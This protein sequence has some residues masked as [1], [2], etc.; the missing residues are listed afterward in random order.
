MIKNLIPLTL[1]SLFIGCG[2]GGSSSSKSIDLAEYFPQKSMIKS[3]TE[4]IKQDGDF[5][6]EESRTNI[7]VEPNIITVK[8]DTAVTSIITVLEDKI[9]IEDRENNHTKVFER[10]VNKNDTLFTDS[11]S[12]NI[13]PLKLGT[14]TYGTE[15]TQREENCKLI[16]IVDDFS[17]PPFYEYNNY[18]K[19]HDILKI[20]CTAKTVV[21]TTIKPEYIGQVTR[22]NGTITSANNIYYLYFQ[23]ELG[24]I[25]QIDDDCVIK[26]TPQIEID[27]EADKKQCIGEKYHYIMYHREY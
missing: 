14:E 16:D 18:D 4:T 22:E 6:T 2:G 5:T 8:N 15:T 10:K 11:Y 3:Y 7:I 13:T 23:K 20:K 25:A 19:E 1:A 17:L 26:K 9:T 27:D 12:S 21:A 24:Q